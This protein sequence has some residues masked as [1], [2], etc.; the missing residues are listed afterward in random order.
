MP[1]GL[2]NGVPN[3]LQNGAPNG[4]HDS[5]PN[6]QEGDAGRA[7]KRCENGMEAVPFWAAKARHQ[8]YG[9]A[10]CQKGCT[11]GCQTSCILIEAE[12]Y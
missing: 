10:G 5:A 7:R 12:A 4:L 3:G 6:K 11:M 1:R 2:Q 8:T 9:K